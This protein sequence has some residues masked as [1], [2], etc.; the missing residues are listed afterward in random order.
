[1][2]NRLKKI[3]FFSPVM[4][5]ICCIKNSKIMFVVGTYLSIVI[6]SSKAI[7]SDWWE[8]FSP[9]KYFLVGLLIDYVVCTMYIFFNRRQ[10]KF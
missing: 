7:N 6:K 9:S 8:D 10:N 5:D 3:Y 2:D 4:H 1:M